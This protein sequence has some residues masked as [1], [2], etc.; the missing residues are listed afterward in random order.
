M[1]VPYQELLDEAIAWRKANGLQVQPACRGE[2]IE[3][4]RQRSKSELGADVPADYCS[5][6]QLSNG[7][8]STGLVVYAS[9]TVPIAGY[10]D[11]FIEGFVEA[12]LGWRDY[13]PNRAFLFFGEDGIRLFAFELPQSR[14]QVL[15][16]QSGSLIQT[17][18]TFNHL[19]S[20]A[21]KS[22]RPR[23]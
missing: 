17:V 9:E 4:L 6:L 20:E 5:F 23:W 8:S 7:L 1:A 21:L 11:R 14:Y 3:A 12:N 19:L 2:A 13:E 18:P 16:R 22:N 10:D 15:D